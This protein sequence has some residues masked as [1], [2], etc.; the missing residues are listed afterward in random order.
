MGLFG[1]SQ[2]EVW[3]QFADEIGGEYIEGGFFKSQKVI[4]KFENWTITLDTFTRS[5]G[6]TSTTYTRMMAPYKTNDEFKFKIYRKG[7]FSE[8]GKVF[9][10]QDIEI[11]YSEFDDE[12]IIKGNNQQKII[13][14]FSSDRI[15]DLIRSQESIL[16]EIKDNKGW[17]SDNSEE[18]V[19]ELYFESIGVI[20][21]IER[22]KN[23]FILFVLVLNRLIIIGS[24][25]DG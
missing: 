8:L 20:K 7:I 22:L 2:R 13:E 25:I 6:K 17:F 23:L 9:G 5:T 21:D 14:L 1:P 12:F 19:Y 11:G 4:G 3:Q 10:M 18:G 15:R 24:A 16:L